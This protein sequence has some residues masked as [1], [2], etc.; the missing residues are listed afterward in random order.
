MLFFKKDNL[1]FEIIS[2][3][4][5]KSKIIIAKFNIPVPIKKNIGST[6]SKMIAKN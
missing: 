2:K 3:I 6:H 5:I 1:F 4:N